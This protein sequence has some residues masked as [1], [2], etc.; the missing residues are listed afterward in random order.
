[1]AASSSD[2]KG[3]AWTLTGGIGGAMMG[4]TIA[5]PFGAIVGCGDGRV[6]SIVAR[7][8]RAS[9]GS[10]AFFTGPMPTQDGQPA[11]GVLPS[12]FQPS[13]AQVSETYGGR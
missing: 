10:R 2:L 6:A 4:A 9:I 7:P 1:M 11:G 5:G 13:S 8:P 12:Q 3:P